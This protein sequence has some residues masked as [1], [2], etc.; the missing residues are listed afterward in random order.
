LAPEVAGAVL[1][2]TEKNPDDRYADASEAVAELRR[3]AVAEARREPGD[4]LGLTSQVLPHTATVRPIGIS[5]G[6]RGRRRTLPFVG[7]AS[8]LL[9]LRN[10]GGD[11][12][13]VRLEGS[14]PFER[15][16]IDVPELVVVPPRAQR[17]VSVSVSSRIRLLGSD[18]ALPFSIAATPADGGSSM[19]ATGEIEDGVVGGVPLLGGGAVVLLLMAL[20]VFVM[21][22][23]PD[24]DVA[25]GVAA[26]P[27]GAGAATAVATATALPAATP[28]S[29]EPTPSPGP[30]SAAA[31]AVA[32]PASSR[33]CYDVTSALDSVVLISSEPPLQTV[34]EPGALVILRAELRVLLDSHGTASVTVLAQVAGAFQA[35]GRVE[36]SRGAQAPVVVGPVLAAAPSLTLRAVMNPPTETYQAAGYDCARSLVEVDLGTYQVGAAPR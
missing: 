15:C 5:L 7:A 26:Q 10:D 27:R 30:P 25:P 29:A 24:P 20:A 1:R 17:A 31:D 14:D 33:D 13:E 16:T 36:V 6:R 32:S 9:T 28:T 2:L 23:Q 8:F 19:V 4:P 21:L 11:A 3:L 35:L 18:R 34:I 12:V 22:G